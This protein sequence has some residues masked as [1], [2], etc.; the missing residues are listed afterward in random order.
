MP[1]GIIYKYVFTKFN[2]FF[3][4]PDLLL[5]NHINQKRLNN[6]NEESTYPLQISAPIPIG[7]F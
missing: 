6:Y 3:K 1:K 2:K 4:K 7:F 5:R